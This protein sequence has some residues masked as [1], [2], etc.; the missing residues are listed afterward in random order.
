MVLVPGANANCGTLART[1]ATLDVSASFWGA[2]D[3][4]GADPADDVCNELGGTTTVGSNAS[5]EITVKTAA[6]R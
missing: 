3:G 1:G 6:G 4:P 2:P 5:R